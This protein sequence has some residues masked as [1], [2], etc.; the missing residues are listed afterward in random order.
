MLFVLYWCLLFANALHPSLNQRNQALRKPPGAQLSGTGSPSATATRLGLTSFGLR[1]LPGPGGID[2]P[3][4]FSPTRLRVWVRR[5]RIAV[6]AAGRRRA[7]P[8]RLPCGPPARVSVAARGAR[9]LGCVRVSPTRQHQVQFRLR[10]G[11][12]SR[13]SLGPP[14]RPRHYAARVLGE[15]LTWTRLAT[16]RTENRLEAGLAPVAGAPL[17]DLYVLSLLAIFRSR[18]A[19]RARARARDVAG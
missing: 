17:R 4:P 10:P 1:C 18:P 16:G 6:L 8:S 7:P 3:A 11:E 19:S 12:L 14:A 15:P 9:S 5:F 13:S 2:R